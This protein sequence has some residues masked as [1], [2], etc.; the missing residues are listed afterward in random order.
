MRITDFARAGHTPSLAAALIH[1]DVSFMAW[2]MLGA[3]GA[4]I[5]EDLGLSASA[6]GLMVAVP[7]L[8][9]AFFRL[10]LGALGDRFGPRRVGT[11]SMAV[12]VAPLLYGWLGADAYGELLAVGVL[13]GVAGASF[14]VSLPLASRWYP[15][16]H[17]G[18]AM[19]IAGAGNSGTVV[20]A[21]AAPRLAEAYGWSAVF[22][23]ALIPVTLALLAFVLLAKEPP[24]PERPLTL[25]AARRVLRER[26]AWRLCGL[27]AVTFGGFVGLASF[28]PVLLHDQ[29]GLTKVDAATVTAAG[30]ALGSLLRPVGGLLADRSGGLAVLTGVFGLAA[31]LL[32]FVSGLPPAGAAA[33]AF[34]VTMGALG[35]GNG[36]VFQLV[37]LRFGDRIGVLTGLVGA[38]GGLG[39][40]FLP[41][42]LG[43]LRDL[44]GS[45]GPG[46]ALVAAAA[47]VALGATMLLRGTWRRVVA[48]AEAPA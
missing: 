8:A 13:L 22:G 11:A 6:K 24:P 7:L 35:A 34:V 12:V 48:V 43:A 39:G 37:G 28:L 30:A 40:F 16:E 38:A 47:A 46:L 9:A 42:L 45:Y 29:Y 18:L 3:L 4:F 41:S 44:S 21:L 27:Y 32:L 14:A 17:Q 2:V 33:V 10:L 1:F 36:A 26:D 31:A 19:G 15:P 5:G 20:T 25:A 23:L